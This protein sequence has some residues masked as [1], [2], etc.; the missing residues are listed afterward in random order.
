MYKI[1]PNPRNSQCSI[2]M[3]R[4]EL[5]T[6]E[7]NEFIGCF[8]RKEV[9]E[10]VKE[11]LEKYRQEEIKEINLFSWYDAKKE[12]KVLSFNDVPARF[13]WIPPGSF[14][15]GDEVYGQQRITTQGFWMQTTPVTQEQWFAIMQ[16]NPAYFVSSGPTA[17]VENVS[18]TDV[19]EFIRRVGHVSLPSEAEWEY[20]CRA[21]ST[22]KYHF[23]D[24]P[25]L[26]QE[27][28]W[29]DKNA[30]STTHSVAQ[31]KPNTW[32]LYD[33]HGNV[34]EW[35]QD[36]WSDTHEG[37]NADG[38]ARSIPNDNTRE[39]VIRGGSW[40]DYTRN[41]R[42]ASRSWLTPSNRNGDLGFRLM[43]Y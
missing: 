1:V 10:G 11:A 31:L 42:A 8:A 15:M 14:V 18:F 24:D 43:F 20:A 12:Q 28:A 3:N 30:G 37:A 5:R 2:T 19:Q 32:D 33:M 36:H 16:N 4:W 17:P 35:C 38:I 29:Y 9:A 40:H 7:R 6:E 39:R 25:D 22:T 21:G 27:Y 34:W 13:A 41:C 26:L 23:G